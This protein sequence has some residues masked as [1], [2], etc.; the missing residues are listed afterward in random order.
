MDIQLPDWEEYESEFEAHKSNEE[1]MVFALLTANAIFIFHNGSVQKIMPD[2]QEVYKFLVLNEDAY[3]RLGPPLSPE[4]LDQ[5]IEKGELETV[6]F[7]DRYMITDNDYTEFAGD[8]TRAYKALKRNMEPLHHM[9]E[10]QEF[11]EYADIPGYLF[12][13]IWYKVEHIE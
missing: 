9:P 12:E 4:D 2:Q 3:N 11:Q 5:L 13:S 7:G 8:I 6:I 1:T 10:T